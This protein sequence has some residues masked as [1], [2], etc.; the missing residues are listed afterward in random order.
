MLGINLGLE[1]HVLSTIEQNY[2]GDNERCKHKMLSHWLRNVK[3]PTW[4]AV[5]DALRLMG[6]NKIALKIQG[7]YCIDTGKR[8]Y[9]FILD[10]FTAS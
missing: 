9:S 6:E 2:R 8:M 1:D 3:L 10:S 5:A 4:K 7:K